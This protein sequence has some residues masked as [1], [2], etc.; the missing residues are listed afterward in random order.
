M[1]PKLR[2]LIFLAL[3]LLSA[4]NPSPTV[5]Q[6]TEGKNINFSQLHDK[7][8]IINYWA[9][10]CEPCFTEIP[11]LN[12]FHHAQKDKNVVILGVN[13]D[14]VAPSKLKQIV[15]QMDIQF[16]VLTTD[17]AKHLGIETLPG[18]P[19]TYVFAPKGKLVRKLY[20]PQTQNDLEKVI[21]TQI[22][23]SSVSGGER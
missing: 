2:L 19:A 15:Q 1:M 17:P 16:P 18:L 10:W 3:I 13:Y 21:T 4:C 5:Y 22:P 14:F 20:G 12:A 6:D 23:S 8:I 11:A 7:W 9:S